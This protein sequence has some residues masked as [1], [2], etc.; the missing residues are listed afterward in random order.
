[1]GFL[2]GFTEVTCW[3]IYYTWREEIRL[4]VGLGPSEAQYD[5]LIYMIIVCVDVVVN[6]LLISGAN[7]DYSGRRKDLRKVFFKT[8]CE[9]LRYVLVVFRSSPSGRSFQA[10]HL[11][12]LGHL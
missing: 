1:M 3:V 5:L 12:F 9:R 7:K 10:G 4:S 2:L 8:N 11:E 6:I